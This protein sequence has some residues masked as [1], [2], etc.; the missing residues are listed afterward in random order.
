MA[1]YWHS[2]KFYSN[3]YSLLDETLFYSFEALAG[4]GMMV[5]FIPINYFVS[6]ILKKY[7]E[8]KMK[9]TDSRIKATND[10]LNGIKVNIS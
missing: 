6:R 7:R 10:M 8:K 5:V 4:L 2:C 3:F 9:Q 1:L